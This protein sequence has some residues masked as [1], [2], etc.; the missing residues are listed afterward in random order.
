MKYDFLEVVWY[1]ESNS[2]VIS[3]LDVPEYPNSRWPPDT[4]LKN[5]F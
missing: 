1:A 5:R 2:G 3:H 4:I